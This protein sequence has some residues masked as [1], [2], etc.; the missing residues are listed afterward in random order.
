[1]RAHRSGAMS[2]GEAVWFSWWCSMRAVRC[3]VC[4]AKAMIAATKCPTCGHLFEL[5][6]GFGDLLPLAYCSSCASYYPESLGACRWCGTKPQR[7]PIGPKV[8]RGAGAAVAVLLGAVWIVQN[9][10]FDPADVRSR[11]VKSVATTATSPAPAVSQPGLAV[12]PLDADTTTARSVATATDANVSPPPAT[13]AD[14]GVGSPTPQVTHPVPAAPAA[15]VALAPRQV[16]PQG[17]S[18]LPS[19]LAGSEVRAS[20]KSPVGKSVAA[21]SPSRRSHWVRSVSR[22]WVIVHSGA[23]RQSRV[24]ASIGPNSRVELGESRG[25]WR[26]IRAKGLSGWVEPRSSFELIAS[27]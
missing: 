24:V 21:A 16:I 11:P 25:E 17:V 22:H 13:V 6:D 10:A 18:R 1:M 9:R 8:W 14:T 26:R 12:S 2:R 20:A 3:D 19:S 4:G 5:R 23:S 15:P 7:P 27:R